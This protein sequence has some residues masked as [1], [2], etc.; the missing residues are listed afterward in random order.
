MHPKYIFLSTASVSLVTAQFTEISISKQSNRNYRHP[1][2]KKSLVSQP[3]KNA[4]I[5]AVKKGK[6]WQNLARKKKLQQQ[7]QQKQQ[8]QQEPAQVKSNFHQQPSPTQTDTFKKY[9]RIATSANSP[10]NKEDQDHQD[11]VK[12]T[13]NFCEVQNFAIFIDSGF[14]LS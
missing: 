8:Q 12:G 11:Q 10:Y 2:T 5:P 3:N 9:G 1:N 13:S 7:Q 6:Y 4:N 14:I